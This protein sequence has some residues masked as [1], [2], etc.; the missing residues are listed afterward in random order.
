MDIRG[1]YQNQQSLIK[2]VDGIFQKQ[3]PKQN[4]GAEQTGQT[5]F[6]D[7]LKQQFNEVNTQSLNAEKAMQNVLSGKEPNP[8]TALIAMQ[9][10]D[11]SFRLLM[12]VKE[13]IT[14]A[15]QEVMRMPIG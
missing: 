13:R 2:G 1:I 12:T 10:A 5:T 9:K 6:A 7:Y 15:Y 8:H 14:Q 11:I 3:G 4:E